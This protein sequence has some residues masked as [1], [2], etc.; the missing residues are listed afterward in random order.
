MTTGSVAHIPL[1]LGSALAALAGAGVRWCVERFVQAPMATSG[2][3]LVAGLTLMGGANALFMQDARHPAPLFVSGD[4]GSRI[5]TP[6][7]VEPVVVQPVERPEGLTTQ[8]APA[9]QPTPQAQTAPV[10]PQE[11]RSVGNA[12]IAELQQKLQALGLFDG[13]IDGFYG[14]KTADAIR[15]FES[16]FDMPRTG[17]ASPQVLDAVR[18]APLNGAQNGAATQQQAPVPP[19]PAQQQAQAQPQQQ[20]SAAPLFDPSAQT[21]MVGMAQMGDIGALIE[22]SEPATGHE[23]GAQESQPMPERVETAATP[24]ITETVMS[25]NPLNQEQ[26]AQAVPPSRDRDLVSTVQRGLNRLGFLQAPVNG[27]ADATTARAIRQFQIFHNYR[28]TGEVTLD[29]VDMLEAAGAYM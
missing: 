2:I 6:P 4:A 13:T 17:A 23:A 27:V 16:R 20:Q 5:N 10:Q 26:A 14:P 15:A 11:S 25:L 7:P 21:N 12:D 22:D 8:S 1:A 28:P 29:L 24:S 18:R 9:A 3:V 19:Q